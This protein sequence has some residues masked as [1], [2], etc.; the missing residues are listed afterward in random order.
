MID[1][2]LVSDTVPPVHSDDSLTKV[3]NAMRGYNVSQLPVVDDKKYVGVV[4]MDELLSVNDQAQLLKDSNV[5]LRKAYVLRTAHFFDMLRVAL[6]Y[7]VR[8]VP[9]VDED[10]QY[11]GLISSETCMRAFAMLNSVK[12]AG[13]VIELEI[14]LKDFL[15]S[16]VTRIVE[17][18]E[19]R[20]L[21]LYTNI[22]QHDMTVLV[23]MK[24][25]TTEVATMIASFERFEYV[26]KGVHNDT[27]YSEGLKDRYDAF[28]RYL[29]I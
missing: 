13:A 7:N 23:T 27:E 20:I 15:L 16:E 21:C 28:M 25:N 3:L 12:D 22:N 2:S 11:L 17:D 19:S 5:I 10:H 26:V 1:L 4:T 8:I 24:V 6:D 14:P 9:V 29:N 18:N